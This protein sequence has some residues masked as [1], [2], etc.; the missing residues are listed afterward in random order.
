LTNLTY[1]VSNTELRAFLQPQE[2]LNIRL[3]QKSIH[4]LVDPEPAKKALKAAQKRLE[5]IN[6]VRTAVS[7]LHQ[8][9]ALNSNF[10][11]MSAAATTNYLDN[12]S[13]YYKQLCDLNVPKDEAKQMV[14]CEW[15][16]YQPGFLD[17]LE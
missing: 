4:Q 8:Q 1:L 5:D 17:R 12:L 15:A 2:L 13:A 9:I 14:Q 11:E 3:T 7:G 16:S 6:H 10:G